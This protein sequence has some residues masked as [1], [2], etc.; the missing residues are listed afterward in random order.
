MNPKK[1][2]NMKKYFT[3]LSLVALVVMTMTSCMHVKVGGKDWSLDGHKNNTPTQVHQVDQETAMNAFDH[4]NVVGPFNVIYTQGEGHN[5]RVKGTAEQLAKMTIY[6]EDGELY[7]DYRKK[8][9]S[10]TFDGLQVFVTSTTLEGVDLAGSGSVTVPEA[11]K[12][13]DIRLELAG[14]GKI[15]LAQLNCNDLTNEI[16]GS[17]DVTMG[18]VQANSVDNDIA[19]S[20]N[21]EIASL[22]CKQVDNDIA[23]SGDIKINGM[24]VEHVKNDIA[25]SGDIHLNGN[26]GSHEDDIAGSGKVHINE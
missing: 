8:E 9:P 5:V 11:L 20:G 25:G 24:N 12:V 17:G 3:I 6:V 13:N 4:V 1:L 19:G 15:T 7:I 26:I 21:I 23:G 2:K 22:T 14:S 10:G 16:A 18:I